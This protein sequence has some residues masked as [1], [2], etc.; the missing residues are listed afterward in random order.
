[1]LSMLACSSATTGGAG[2]KRRLATLILPSIS[3]PAAAG[4]VGLEPSELCT[5]I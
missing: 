3:S 5:N 4:V 1:M 2:V